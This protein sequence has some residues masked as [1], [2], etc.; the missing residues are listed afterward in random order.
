[1]TALVWGLVAWTAVNT[2]FTF[3]VFIFI[4]YTRGTF[5]DRFKA[6]Q[7]TFNRVEFDVNTLDSRTK[8]AQA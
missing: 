4:A 3:G 1:M 5:L 6:I 7:D 2:M 8:K